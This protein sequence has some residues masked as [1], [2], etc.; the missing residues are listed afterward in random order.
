M[1]PSIKKFT[2]IDENTTSYS[3]NAI[4][5]SA[6]KRVERDADLVLRKPKLKIL[7]QPLDD[8]LL[9]TDRRFK[10]YKA[11]E[12]RII[13]KEGFLF[14]K[15][16]GQTGSVKH[17]QI[18]IPKQLVN[19]VRRSLHGEFEKHPGITKP[20]MA[21]RESIITQIWLKLSGS[22]LCHANNALRNHGLIP[23]SPCRTRMRTLLC[24]KTPCKTI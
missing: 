5:A 18:L 23:N 21:Y 14:P 13:L 16:Y 22:G 11:N 9:L 15:Y 8:V 7:G 10:H 3:I 20:I 4:K 2:K 19:E 17:C 6:R 12:D 24:Q 1:K